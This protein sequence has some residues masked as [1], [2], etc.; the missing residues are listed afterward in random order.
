MWRQSLH[1]AAQKKLVILCRLITKTNYSKD[2]LRTAV[3]SQL[4]TDSS[5]KS[6]G[7]TVSTVEVFQWFYTCNNIQSSEQIYLTCSWHEPHTQDTRRNDFSF[8]TSTIF[9]EFF[10]TTSLPRHE[11]WCKFAPSC[12]SKIN[13]KLRAVKF[14]V[15]DMTIWLSI[16]IFWWPA[17]NRERCGSKNRDTDEF[18]WAYNTQGIMCVTTKW[19]PL[20]YCVLNDNRNQ[21]QVMKDFQ[22]QVISD[23]S[24]CEKRTSW[25][26]WHVLTPIVY[27]V[28]YL[29]LFQ[30]ARIWSR[31][32]SD[33]FNDTHSTCNTW[34]TIP[35]N[36]AT[37]IWN[38]Q[39]ETDSST[40]PGAL[41]LIG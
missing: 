41:V 18:S 12:A 39:V 19:R 4:W 2:I 15:Q 3:L 28:Y 7:S 9:N 40:R 27:L 33:L 32:L 26:Q 6:G 22:Q 34:D 38:T 35:C 20:I 1:W 17:N 8:I 36:G 5:K 13:T 30:K 14:V 16:H 24:G 29:Y 21:L 25:Y 23:T 11:Q 31:I 10:V 37:K